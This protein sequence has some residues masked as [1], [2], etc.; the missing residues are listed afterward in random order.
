[1]KFSTFAV[2]FLIGAVD[3]DADQ[4][5]LRGGFT[6]SDT[7]GR[8]LQTNAPFQFPDFFETTEP[9]TTTA[10]PFEFQ[11]FGP[12]TPNLGGLSQEFNSFANYAFDFDFGADSDSSQNCPSRSLTSFVSCLEDGGGPVRCGPD[13]CEYDSVCAAEGADFAEDV[14]FLVNPVVA[15]PD[16]NGNSID[17]SACPVPASVPCPANF[18]PVVC[19]GA[20]QYSNLCVAENA[21]FAPEEY[22][23]EPSR[24][25]S[26]RYQR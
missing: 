17:S 1:M 11:G 24:R 10:N 8:G 9:P 21:E 18:D 19:G 3:I 14:C 6:S 5:L 7:G 23:P 13:D 12:T 2:L 26:V 22:T 16:N 4:K 15:G 20:C 25:T